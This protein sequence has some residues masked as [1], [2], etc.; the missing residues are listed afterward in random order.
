[1]SVLADR[2]TRLSPAKKARFLARV[3]HWATVGARA[4]GYEPGTDR[5]DGRVLRDYMEF[6]HRVTGYIAVVLDEEEGVGQD[7]SVMKMIEGRDWAPALWAALTKAL[8]EHE[9]A[10]LA[11]P[12]ARSNRDEER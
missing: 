10:A 4:D 2:F 9:V 6:I 7:E 1:M 5:A 3:A 8:D 12:T 11:R